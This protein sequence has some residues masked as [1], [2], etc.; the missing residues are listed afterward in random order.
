MQCE[1]AAMDFGCY[2]NFSSDVL[3]CDE[4]AE[5]DVDGYWLCG[6]CVDALEALMAFGRAVLRSRNNQGPG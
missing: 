4:I 5:V 2:E 1:A 6:G 3:P